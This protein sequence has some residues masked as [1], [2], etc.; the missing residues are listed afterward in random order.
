MIY[1]LFDNKVK[2]VSLK[3]I[4]VEKDIYRLKELTEEEI[5]FLLKLFEAR[6]IHLINDL[7]RDWIN[8]F[9]RVFQ[10]KRNTKIHTNQSINTMIDELEQNLSE[11]LHM[12]I[13]EFGFSYLDSLYRHDCSFFENE[14]KKSEFLLFFF[15]QFCRTKK[16]K[17]SISSINGRGHLAFDKAW[18]IMVFIMATN[19]AMRIFAE[20]NDWEL[21][22]LSNNSSIPFITS[23]QPI[24]NLYAKNT[25]DENEKLEK[26]EFELYYP[27]APQIAVVLKR[28]DSAFIDYKLLNDITINYLNIKMKNES[29]LQVFSNSKDYLDV[30]KNA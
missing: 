8:I 16:M 23:D 21:I 3:D 25:P 29:Y 30:I 20:K 27:I 4:A 19:V 10:Y 24:I 6:D 26:N 9:H 12:R 1:Y 17:D 13:E 22:L 7:N 28:K 14:D 11:D 15:V 18:N 2:G 5:T